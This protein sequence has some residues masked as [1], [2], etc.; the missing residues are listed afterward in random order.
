MPLILMKQQ[1]FRDAG[2]LRCFW[3]RKNSIYSILFAI[4]GNLHF[5]NVASEDGGD[6]MY[7]CFAA[8]HF[9]GFYTKGRTTELKVYGK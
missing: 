6:K 7:S 4:V 8:L 9:I 2:F 5:A 1:Y 3:K